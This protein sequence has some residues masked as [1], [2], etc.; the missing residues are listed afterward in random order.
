P[1]RR[2]L[3][4]SS[5]AQVGRAEPVAGGTGDPAAELAGGRVGVGGTSHCLRKGMPVELKQRLSAERELRDLLVHVGSFLFVPHLFSVDRYQ[6]AG[7]TQGRPQE[8]LYRE[9][10]RRPSPCAPAGS[11][12]QVVPWTP[13]I[14]PAVTP[15]THLAIDR[16][17]CGEPLDAPGSAA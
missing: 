14:I 15:R 2:R 10:V 11:N 16:R 17:L 7:L 9:S 4:R 13:H 8:L 6:T 1:R 3:G 5:E 12:L